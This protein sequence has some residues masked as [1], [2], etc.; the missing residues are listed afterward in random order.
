MTLIG[1]LFL[2]FSLKPTRYLSHESSQ[3]GWKPLYGLIIIFL[4][5]Y[6]GFIYYLLFHF[7]HF[8][9]Y[10]AFSL[11]FCLGGLFVFMV[12]KLSID[13]YKKII[14]IAKETEYKSLHDSLT[15]LPNRKHFLKEI[16]S[17]IANATPFTLFSLD[18]NNFKQVN[19]ALGHYYGDKL[20]IEIA[21]NISYKLDRMTVIFR[22]GGDEFMV[23]LKDSDD[24]FYSDIIERIH[25]AFNDTY[26]IMHYSIESSVS[27]G[28]TKFPND[29]N[30]LD[31]L[32]KYVD[33]AMYVSKKTK[34][35]CVFYRDELN[36]DA[37]EKLAICGRLRNAIA[38]NEFQIYFQPLLECHSKK[39]HGAEVLIRW[40]QLDG[41][42]IAPDI[43]IPIAEKAGLIQ[44]ITLWVIDNAIIQLASLDKNGFNGVLHINLSAKDLHTESL[45]D[46]LINQLEKHPL[47]AERLIFEVTESAMMLDLTCSKKMMLR[48]SEYGFTFSIDDFG[49]GFSSLSL[50]RELPIDQI[51]ID[52]SFVQHMDSAITDHAIVNSAIFLAK[53]LGCTVVAEGVENS[54]LESELELLN[55]DYL[56]G[57]YYSEPIPLTAFIEHYCK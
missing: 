46:L 22:T 12:T 40:P 29:S 39:L 27:V 5:G 44:S 53:N 43:F 49:T 15:G 13:S 55:C 9:I 50:L 24:V 35:K 7:Q 30:N 16:S 20:L 1:S 28:A 56:Q 14:D 33:L 25:S 57:Y 21:Q 37:A 32:I 41:S 18:L 36:E 52:R 54:A 42:F 17:L 51:K 6:Q 8:I 38:T 2:L 34:S 48:L 3:Q 4:L 23:I 11:I 47:L 45:F 26:Q 19:D 10:P 31:T